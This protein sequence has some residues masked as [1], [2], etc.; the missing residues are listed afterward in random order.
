MGLEDARDLWRLGRLSL[1]ELGKGTSFAGQQVPD[2]AGLWTSSPYA[3][4]RQSR[5]A[6]T[7]ELIFDSVDVRRYPT[8]WGFDSGGARRLHSFFQRHPEAIE[9]V[10][11]GRFFLTADSAAP[12]VTL[13]GTPRIAMWPVHKDAVLNGTTVTPDPV[14]KRDPCYDHKMVLA[15]T[16]AGSHYFVQRSEPG[17]GGNDFEA[18]AGGANKRLMGYLQRLTDRPVP[19]FDRPVQ[20]Y[21]S[22]ADKYGDDRDAILLEMLDYLRAT[23]FSDGQ[24]A[25]NMQFSVLCPGV[26]HKGFGQVSPLQ[27]RVTGPPAGT[28]NH[29]QGLGRAMTVSEVALIFTCRAEVDAK[30][31]LKGSPT[32]ANRALLVNPGDREIEAGL[33]VEGFVPGQGWTDYR[34]Y[35][36]VALVGGAPGTAPS[37]SAALPKLMVNQVE[38]TL[39]SGGN[40]MESGELPPAEWQGAGGSI[41]LRSLT[42]GAILFKPVVLKARADGTKEPLSFAGGSTDPMQLK[43][44]V[45][46]SPGSISAVDLLQVIPIVLPDI[47]STGGVPAPSLSQGT[48]TPGL[49]ARLKQAAKTGKWLI[50]DTDVVQSL[51]PM[52]GDYRLTATQRWAESRNAGV[53]TPV[54][55]PHPLWGKQRFAHTLRDAAVPG[56]SG[57]TQGYIEGLKYASGQRPDIPATLVAATPLVALWKSGVWVKSTLTSAIDSMRLDEGVRGPALPEIT[58]DFDNGTGAVPDGPYCNRPDDGHWAAAKAGKIPY[59]DNVSQ[60]GATVP[61][62]SAAMFSAQRLLPSPVMFGS[63]PT[64]TRTQVP[65]QTLLFRPQP[66]HY[67]AKSPPD[68]LLL[69]LFWSPV[70]EPEPVSQAFETAGKINLNHEILPFRYIKRTTALHA[71]MKA[72]TITAIPDSASE[73]YKSGAAPK[74]RFRHY[75]DVNN[76]LKLWQKTVFDQGQVFLTAGQ[77]CEQPLVPEGLVSPGEEPT[78]GQVQQYWQTHRLTGDNTKERPYARLYSRLT[79][80]SNTFR[81]HF[82]A[83]SLKKARSTVADTFDASKDRVLATTRGSALLRRELNTNDPAIPDYQVVSAPGAGPMKPLDDFY[84]W[85]CVQVEAGR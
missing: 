1:A 74:D 8:L 67:G 50:A 68:H 44:A 55:V 54:F 59:F 82:I 58:G 78:A 11:R 7:D 12:E 63:L 61:P 72:E 47:P 10:A 52:H 21:A 81:V 6:T 40:A 49:S 29:A 22:F 27:Q 66:G 51:A 2:W 24:L 13:Y 32:P 38:L 31:V 42:D 34:P 37:R 43:L 46:D 23:N 65:W 25:D 79:T 48:E 70:I 62:V 20:G 77:I 45:Y 30:G 41:G 33:L 4:P 15:G 83:Q 57:S 75:V 36:G 19:G 17:N 64:G 16:L 76:T 28:S 60:T 3:I 73:T 69:D 14:M 26:E 84:R 35:I 18:H 56:E 80:R 53:A 39:A 9:R 71:A 5:Y 85:R